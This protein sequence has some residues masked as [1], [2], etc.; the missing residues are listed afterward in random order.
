[1]IYCQLS[2]R[3]E[4]KAGQRLRLGDIAQLFGCPGAEDVPL[5][6]PDQPGVWRI[7]ALSC[8]RALARAFPGEHITLLGAPCCNVRRL[9]NAKPDRLKPLR[10]LVGMLILLMGSALG[11][12]WFHSDVD[13]PAAMESVYTLLT[14]QEVADQRLITIPYIIGV[15]LGTAGFY[16]LGKPK[17]ITPLDVKLSDYRDDMERAEAQNAK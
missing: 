3:M 2:A 5:A 13:M 4:L 1:M 11:L 8:A 7:E 16:A 9:P 10:A 12:A 6:C 15:A 17:A 14:G